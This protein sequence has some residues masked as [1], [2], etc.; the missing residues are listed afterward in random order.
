MGYVQRFSAALCLGTALAAPAH[1]Q[2]TGYYPLGSDA[3][4]LT[5]GDFMQL[6]DAANGLLRRSPL[7]VGAATSWRNDKTGATGTIRVTQTFQHDAML[8]HRLVY[9]TIPAGAPTANRTNLNWCNT[10]HGEWKI[11]PS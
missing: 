7:P 2:L 8:C 4:S 6:I 1:A 5:N 10:G 9:E 3:L 11:L